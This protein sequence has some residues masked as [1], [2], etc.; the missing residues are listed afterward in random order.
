MPTITIQPDAT[1][2]LDTH[3]KQ[4][5]PSTN[6]ATGQTFNIGC[7]SSC[8][9]D[10]GRAVIQFDLSS[11]PSA[12]GVVSAILSI[13]HSSN[14][15]SPI[16]ADVYARRVTAQW[17]ESQ[18]TWNNR[19][20][21]TAWGSAGGDATS[22]DQA[23]VNV[24]TT[25]N[26]FRDWTVTAI[27][28]SWVS[29]TNPNYGFHISGQESNTTARKDFNSSD[30]SVA[31]ER[32][33]LVITYT[34]PTVTVTSP[35][36]TQASPTTISDDV[37]PDLSGVYN[38]DVGVD[39]QKRRHWVYDEIGNLVWDS[40][41]VTA[42]ATPGSTVMVTVPDGYLYYGFK[43][44]W[45]WKAW[46]SAGGYSALSS[47]GWFTL[48]STSEPAPNY[49]DFEPGGSAV[50]WE[51]V[52][53]PGM[54]GTHKDKELVGLVLVLALASGATANVQT[55][56]T[57]TGSYSTA[58]A[59]TVSGTDAQVVRVPVPL[60]S[61]DTTHGAVKRVRLT[62]TGHVRLLDIVE[63]YRVRRR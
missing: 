4:G 32:P 25:Q 30:H 40:G 53:G 18:A 28:Q 2:G 13:Y 46:D 16:S 57:E 42:S 12:A 31:G 36:G 9:S 58:K 1:A 59:I 7:I 50:A 49:N 27:V 8:S 62:G 38:N 14:A 35:N 43:G 17:D 63:R 3:L 39:M 52:L 15:G 48:A 19:L 37:T 21:G 33:K 44:Y 34:Q 55:S 45:V 20:T 10:K 56:F 47:Q 26:V 22:T 41:E 29:G 23:W 11:I 6:Y 24:P 61:G 60:N 51:I 54:N 5:D